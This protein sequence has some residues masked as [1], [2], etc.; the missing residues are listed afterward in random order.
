MIRELKF[1]EKD[2]SFHESLS[3]MPLP[4]IK[5]VCFEII[6]KVDLE[7]AEHLRNKL[8]KALSSEENIIQ[9]ES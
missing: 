5:S 6:V 2:N 9:Q 1:I 7:E 4:C 3:A 8:L